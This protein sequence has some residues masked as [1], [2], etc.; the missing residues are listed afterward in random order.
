VDRDDDRSSVQVFISFCSEALA[1]PPC[2]KEIFSGGKASTSS[3]KSSDGVGRAIGRHHAEKP[4]LR[5][6]PEGPAVRSRVSTTMS[7]TALWAPG[8]GRVG[9]FG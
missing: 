8:E 2:P 5:P 1:S 6:A 7:D 9:S 3:K 4:E